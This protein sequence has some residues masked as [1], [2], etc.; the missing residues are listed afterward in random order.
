MAFKKGS[1][2]GVGLRA[3]DLLGYDLRGCFAWLEGGRVPAWLWILVIWA[4][5]VWP[6]IGLRAFH[7]EEGRV[8]AVARGVLEN[9]D[10]IVPHLFGLRDVERPELLAWVVAMLGALSGGINQWVVR[11][12]TVLSLLAGCFMAFHLVRRHTGA[13]AGAFAAV[14]FL[15]SP[16]MLQK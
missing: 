5:L 14:C 12:P 16:M 2:A 9:S 7:Y 8:V 13:L 1:A 4:L 3:Y 6:A 11:A 15:V 10:G